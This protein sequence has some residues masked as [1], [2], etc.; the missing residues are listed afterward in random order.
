MCVLPPTHCHERPHGPVSWPR[1]QLKA[2][3]ALPLG[4]GTH[5]SAQ[6]PLPCRAFWKRQLGPGTLPPWRQARGSLEE[7]LQP[8]GACEGGHGH[9]PHSVFCLQSTRFEEELV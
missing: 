4:H 9:A 3:T 6:V 1:E 7:H 8:S 5:L 2:A